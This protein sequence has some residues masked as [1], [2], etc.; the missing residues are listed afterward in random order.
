MALGATGGEMVCLIMPEAVALAIGGMII[1]GP[2]VWAL[3]RVSRSLLYGTGALDFP[4]VASSVLVLFMFAAVAGIVPARRAA[5]L[6]P[7][8][9]LRCQ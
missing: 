4:A 1:G 9:A 3:A 8:S 2:G 5:R 7:M 6:D